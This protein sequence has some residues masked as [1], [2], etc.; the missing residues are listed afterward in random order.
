MRRASQGSKPTNEPGKRNSKA[1]KLW[2]SQVSGPESLGIG[3]ETTARGLQEDRK[4]HH[5]EIVMTATL[6]CGEA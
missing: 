1:T 3:G 4:I 6:T 2:K 5:Y